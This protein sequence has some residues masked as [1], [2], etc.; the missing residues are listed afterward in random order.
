MFKRFM[1]SPAMAVALL[2]LFVALG[3]GAYAATNLPANSVGTRQLRNQA[4]TIHKLAF[5]SVG[6]RRIQKNAVTSDRVRNGSLLAEDFAAGQLPRGPQGPAGPQGPQGAQGPPGPPG[7]TGTGPQGPQGPRGE[8]GP[9]GPQGDIGPQGEKGDTGK[10]GPEGPQGPAMTSTSFTTHHTELHF[11]SGER[12]LKG[13]P[14]KITTKPG[15]KHLVLN[16]AVLVRSWDHTEITCWY[17]V[18][19]RDVGKVKLPFYWHGFRELSLG[20]AGRIE[21]KP[22]EHTIHVVCHSHGSSI[23]SNH[24]A[25][26][27]T[28][29]YTAIATG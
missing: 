10:T 24:F 22:M 20:L 6:T 16:G 12:E 1:P 25:E 4:V 11:F 15:Q 5:N 7:G 23:T 8:Q 3:G 21:V 19:H 29:H 2:A 14:G 18:D 26:T 28:G 27:L 9:P 13:S 17:L